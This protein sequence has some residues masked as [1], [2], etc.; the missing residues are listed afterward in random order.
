MVDVVVRVRVAA[1]VEVDDV[2]ADD[3]AERLAQR[4]GDAALALLVLDLGLRGLGLGLSI[5]K[6]LAV[7]NGGDV[8]LEPAESGGL[9]AVVLLRRAPT[10][11]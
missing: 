7:A 8:A 10:S 5:V 11:T 4:R 1:V 6:E 2:V 3:V 9:D